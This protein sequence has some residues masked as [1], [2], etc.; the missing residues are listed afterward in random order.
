VLAALASCG[1]HP[2][3]GGSHA[4]SSGGGGGGTGGA[5]ATASSGVGG[6]TPS[7]TSSSSGSDG[8]SVV[9]VC[10]V[11][12]GALAWTASIPAP[13]SSLVLVD[14][15]AGPTND[16]IVAD[17][18]GGTIFEQ[19]RWDSAGALVS[20]HQDSSGAYAGPLWPSNLFV[21]AQNDLFYGLLLT[22]L[23]QG[24]KTGAE[25]TFTRLA[26]SGSA[27]FTLPVTSAMP[28]SDGPPF[29][30]LFLVGGDSGGNLHGALS[31][32]DPQYFQSGVWCYGA[33]GSNLGVSAQT[34]STGLSA[35]DFLWP[36][37]DQGLVLLKPLTASASFG[38]GSALA[39]PAAGGTALGKL[40]GAGTC[41]WNKLLALPKAAVKAS[42]FRLGADGSLVLA[43][44]YAGTIDF[45]GGP[46][47]STG[48]SS[49]AVAR[50]DS[51]GNL[52]WTKSFGG[53]GSHFALGSLAVNATGTMVLTSGY[54]GA[55]DLGGG[56]LPAS[57]DTFV[58]VF[59]LAGNLAWS[60]VVTVGAQ[61]GLM[62]TVSPCAV[63]LATNSPSV[64]LGSGPLSTATPPGAASIGVAALGL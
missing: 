27:V 6:A 1:A 19:H 14:V 4:A 44:V 30:G 3:E 45:G 37:Q 60:K 52:L 33:S 54:A 58:A 49:L 11:A 40:T 63:V 20:D 15:V 48:T 13:P 42:N 24:K 18:S 61:G 56:A 41:V 12:H 9:D 55:V 51:G 26:P 43:V 39:V 29:P 53:T 16:V 25:L 23:P 62:A 8:G 32:G 38:C 22:G 2:G 10:D 50:F 31:M 34:P 36:S 5:T 47:H 17:T 57:A 21:D 64:D 28:A 35:G 46:L 7:S 59:D